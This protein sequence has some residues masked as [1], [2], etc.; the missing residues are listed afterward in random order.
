MQ[1]LVPIYTVK[2]KY[3]IFYDEDKNQ[4]CKKYTGADKDLRPYVVSA[5]L[6]ANGVI[7]IIGKYS[8]N[9]IFSYFIFLLIAILIFKIIIYRI[10]RSLNSISSIYIEYDDFVTNFLKLSKISSFRTNIILFVGV[11]LF[12][13][14]T[15]SFFV[16]GENYLL[17]LISATA[18]VISLILYTNPYK[19]YLI[20]REITQKANIK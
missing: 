2:D 11:I 17:L 20:L 18:I 9:K 5:V 15:L 6:M 12:F 13:I 14:F 10:E 1:N 16:N 7:F 8:E 4:F 19:R 3:H